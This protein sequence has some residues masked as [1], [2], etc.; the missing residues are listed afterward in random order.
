MDKLFSY[1]ASAYFFVKNWIITN[2]YFVQFVMYTGVV[3]LISAVTLI[4]L[5][6]SAPDPQD[7][8]GFIDAWFT[9]I[10]CFSCTGL[11]LVDYTRW[12]PSSLVVILLTVLLGNMVLC[13]CF[14][15]VLRL[16][17]LYRKMQ[18]V[19]QYE[20]TDETEE[21]RKLLQQ[22]IN[23]NVTICYTGAMYVFGFMGFGV[24]LLSSMYP[25]W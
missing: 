8:L 2:R 13:S 15:S 1:V 22:Y 25:M 11:A 19:L 23:V 17:T 14:P 18:E 7:Q 9:A 24:L 16:R 6:S 4:I 3:T 12:Y 10:S 21:F 20:T 5:Q